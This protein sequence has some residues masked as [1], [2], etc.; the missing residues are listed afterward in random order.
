MANNENFVVLIQ[1]GL[2]DATFWFPLDQLT[3]SQLT[4]LE[5]LSNMRYGMGNGDQNWAYEILTSEWLDGLKE[6]YPGEDGVHSEGRC[7]AR[8]IL[9]IY[10]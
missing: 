6:R 4:D 8:I 1:L 3:A 2:D 7:A 10:E 9:V 5:S